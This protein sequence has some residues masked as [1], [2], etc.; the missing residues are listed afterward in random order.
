MNT[1]FRNNLLIGIMTAA[2]LGVFVFT[3]VRASA[4]APEGEISVPAQVAAYE[5][6]STRAVEAT[7]SSSTMTA[8]HPS[9]LQIPSIGVDASVHIEDFDVAVLVIRSCRHWRLPLAIVGGG[10]PAA[11]CRL[12]LFYQK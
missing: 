9:R 3:L 12:P 4:Y 11:I 6:S 5:S 8:E 2:A 10:K 7:D 1:Q